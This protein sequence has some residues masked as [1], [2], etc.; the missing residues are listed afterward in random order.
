MSMQSFQLPDSNVL[1]AVI[2]KPV[3]GFD[4]TASYQLPLF[5]TSNWALFDVAYYL[6]QV[7][8]KR[9]VLLHFRLSVNAYSHYVAYD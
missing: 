1:P 9:A 5:E 2:A 7:L 6:N 3:F 8:S 4:S